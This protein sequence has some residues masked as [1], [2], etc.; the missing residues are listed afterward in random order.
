M[1][2]ALAE[3]HLVEYFSTSH[4]HEGVVH[5]GGA[6]WLQRLD[7][8]VL[9]IEGGRRP[10]AR[11]CL[12]GRRSGALCSPDIVLDDLGGGRLCGS[13][14]GRDGGF[15]SRRRK[16]ARALQRLDGACACLL[17]GGK[18]RP[19]GLLCTGEWRG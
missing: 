12:C 15:G 3:H 7:I 2:D 4:A 19:A 10:C 8:V 6:V 18:E 13:L 11:L 16:A 9:A 5:L 14:E 1:L 17:H